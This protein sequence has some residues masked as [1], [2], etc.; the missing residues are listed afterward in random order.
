MP[1]GAD[2]EEEKNE[3]LASR[4][5]GKKQQGGRQKD[6]K[7]YSAKGRKPRWEQVVDDIKSIVAPDA[8]LGKKELMHAS[9]KRWEYKDR[10]Y[11]QEKLTEAVSLDYNKSTTK[12]RPVDFICEK[13]RF[14]LATVHK[15]KGAVDE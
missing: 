14:V 8:V 11:M 15:Q 12:G 3:P 1:F 5:R 10:K 7:N 13:I 4:K 2:M 6:L 9:K